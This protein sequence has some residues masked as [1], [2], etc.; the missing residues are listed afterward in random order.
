MLEWLKTILGESYTEDI[1]KKVSDQIGKD[2]V[3][4]ADFNAANEAKKTLD[5]QIADRD[6]QL[7]TLKKSSGDSEALQRQIAQLQEQNK[8]A[9][10]EYDGNLKKLTVS[11][12]IETALL[13][14]NARD[15]KAARALLDES[16]IS[17]DGENVLGL[18]DQIDTLKK[19]KG[20][21][22]EDG[23]APKNP[24]APGGGEPPKADAPK[25]LEQAIA[26][27]L[28]AAGETK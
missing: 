8:A 12:K 26:Q 28:G 2:F 22:F 9:K 16:K 3:A 5:E 15:V 17:L 21:L 18:N 23:A 25:T 27:S 19:D 1:D 4:R 10:A 11:S 13:G 24:P 6:K 14:A 7:E 20:W